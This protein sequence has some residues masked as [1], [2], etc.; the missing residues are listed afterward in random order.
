VE[1]GRQTKLTDSDV[2]ETAELNRLQR[3]ESRFVLAELGV[4]LQSRDRDDAARRETVVSNPTSP[5]V[6][7]ET[8]KSECTPAVDEHRRRLRPIS[9]GEVRVLS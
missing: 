4:P 9:T 7:E 6:V 1:T 5:S 8:A 3:L 2:T